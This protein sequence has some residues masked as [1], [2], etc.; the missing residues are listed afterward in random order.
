MNLKMKL[1]GEA[2]A[3]MPNVEPMAVNLD[4]FSIVPGDFVTHPLFPQRALVCV[5]RHIDL[6][7]R[8]V[9][10]FLDFARE[11]DGKSPMH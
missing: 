7:K 3:A 4:P 11:V 8:E 2:L 6:V 10:V 1:V 9:E 5:A